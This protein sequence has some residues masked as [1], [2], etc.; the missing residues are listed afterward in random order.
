MVQE[1]AEPSLKDTRHVV[2]GL[3]LQG[4]DSEEAERRGLV[5]GHPQ[6]GLESK[7]THKTRQKH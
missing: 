1:L 5:L 3:R 4:L 2:L 6:R 7:Q